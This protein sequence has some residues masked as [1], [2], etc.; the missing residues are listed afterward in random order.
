MDWIDILLLLVLFL[1]TLFVSL[2]V[3][4]KLQLKEKDV[5]LLVFYH[6]FFSVAY[7][8]YIQKYGGDANQYYSQ[9]MNGSFDWWPGSRFVTSFTSIFAYVM[10]LGKFNIFLIYN[11]IGLIGLLILTRLVFHFW[12]KSGG[13]VQT[14]R[15]L[16]V[17]MP[18][19]SFWTSAIGKDGPAF[20]A[21]CLAVY[22]FTDIKKKNHLFAVAVAIM[23][24]V[25]PHVAAVLLIAAG[26]TLVLASRAGIVMRSVILATIVAAFFVSFPFVQEYVGLE[27]A[28]SWA[29]LVQYIERRASYNQ[30]GNGAVDITQMSFVPKLFTYLF[31][32]L[33]FDAPGLMGLVVS[34]EN[35]FLLALFVYTARGIVWQVVNVSHPF[36]RFSAIYFLLG[37]VMFAMVTANL[38][39]AIRQKTMILPAFL[40]LVAMSLSHVIEVRRRR[41]R[42]VRPVEHS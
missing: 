37:W 35:L 29:E 20:L 10:H 3:G 8:V 5:L 28:T 13:G 33:F 17:F 24:V 25:R 38:G 31:R 6:T 21:A 15:Y 26:L 22:A 12:P 11:L 16:V 39:I 23:F 9:G 1:L 27:D 2:G 14:M 42:L 30:K 19:L 41:T 18:G 4:R 7:F 34:V 32:P 40:V 36:V